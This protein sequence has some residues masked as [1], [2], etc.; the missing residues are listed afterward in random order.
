M[1]SEYYDVIS[2]YVMIQATDKDDYIDVYRME[3]GKT[4]VEIYRN[5]GGDREDLISQRTFDEE[6]TK[7]VWIYGLDDTDTFTVKGDGKS[8]TLVRLIGGHDDDEYIIENKK[9]LKI[10]DFKADKE[11]KQT[12]ESKL[13]LTKNTIKPVS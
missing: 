6:V 7:E 10:Y 3:D 1:I 8:K 5:K 9:R 4:K 2:E 11:A 13:H 12:A